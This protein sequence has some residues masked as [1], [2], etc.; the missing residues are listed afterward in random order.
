VS[1]IE[2]RTRAGR[3]RWYA[4]WRGD[5]GQQRTRVFDRR[6]DAEQHLARVVVSLSTGAYVDPRRGKITLETFHTTWAARQVGSPGTARSVDLSVRSC[7]FKA[8]PLGKVSPGHVE[9]WVK[10]MT[11]AGLAA[12]TIRQRVDC[13][14]TV[15]R[16]A[17]RDRILAGDPTAGVTLPRVPRKAS[18]MR[19]PT[20]EQVAAVLD[21]ADDTIRVGLTLAAFAGLRSGEV[22]GL[23]TGDVDWFKRV[24]QVRRQV[25]VA[26][27]QPVTRAPKSKASERSIPVAQGVLDCLAAHLSTVVDPTFVI[28]RGGSPHTPRTFGEGWTQA[29][30]AAGVAGFTLHD[31]RHWYASGLIAAGL[32]V[33]SVQHALGH[34]S[35]TVTLSTYSHLWPTAEDR[36][37]EAS[38]ALFGQV[39]SVPSKII[40]NTAGTHP[41]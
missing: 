29:A 20:A 2:K 35:A 1:S 11:S 27:G 8:V 22:C 19:I 23:Q 13:V 39:A 33:V 5:D 37:R 10:T 21:A 6:G 9:Q 25:Q 38:A 30:A 40:G 14:R 24:I 31:L 36:T 7:T 12:S 41:A 18:T 26:G 16:S 3:I 15:L 28:T 4:R 32:D 17:V 34:G